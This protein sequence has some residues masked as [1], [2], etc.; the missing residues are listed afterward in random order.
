MDLPVFRGLVPD[1]LGVRRVDPG[2]GPRVVAR[3]ECGTEV[4]CQQ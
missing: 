1:P 3:N 2:N 4:S